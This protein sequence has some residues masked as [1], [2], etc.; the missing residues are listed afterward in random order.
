DVHESWLEMLFTLSYTFLTFYLEFR[1][2]REKMKFLRLIQQHIG[3]ASIVFRNLQKIVPT[4]SESGRFSSLLASCPDWSEKILLTDEDNMKQMVRLSRK[5]KVDLSTWTS[6]L[7]YGKIGPNNKTGI[8]QILLEAF[9]PDDTQDFLLRSFSLPSGRRTKVLNHA[10]PLAWKPGMSPFGIIVECD[11]ENYAILGNAFLEGRLVMD[12]MLTIQEMISVQVTGTPIDLLEAHSIQA[13]AS[14]ENDIY[15]DNTSSMRKDDESMRK[16][17]ESMR[18]DD[19]SM[20][21]DDESMRKDETFTKKDLSV[22]DEFNDAMLDDLSDIPDYDDDDT[23]SEDEIVETIPSIVQSKPR[24]PETASYRGRPN[25]SVPDSPVAKSKPKVTP[26]G[27]F[28]D[29]PMKPPNIL[30][31]CGKKDSA[32]NYEKV[33]NSLEQ[34]VNSDSYVIYNLKHDDVMKVPWEDNAAL[35]VVTS[36]RLY[37]GLDKAFMKFYNN[38]GKI[39]SFNSNL[40]E[41]FLPRSRLSSA[42]FV[43]GIAYKN[44]NLNYICGPFY[45]DIDIK[46]SRYVTY[47]IDMK[48]EKPLMVRVD[49]KTSAGVAM[50]SQICLDKDPY[51]LAVSEET[52][53]LLQQSNDERFN[54][55]GDILEDLGIDCSMPD[56]PALTPAY[57]LSVSEARAMMFLHALTPRFNDDGILKST[58]GVS[59]QFIPHGEYAPEPRDDFLPVI[60]GR[61]I[62]STRFDFETY[63]KYLDADSLGKIIL[64]T[65]VIPTTMDVFDPMMFYVPEEINVAC[66]AGRQ[67][68]GKGRGGN[69]WLSPEGCAMFSLHMNIPLQSPLGQRVSMI[70]HIAALAVT[71]A[72]S[73]VPEYAA[74]NIK[75][76]WPNDIYFA[77]KVKIGGVFVKSTVLS[78]RLHAIIG[79]GV[80]VENSKP[81]LCLNDVVYQQNIKTGANLEMWTR[82][83]LI[84]RTFTWMEHLI[85][86]IQ[87]DQMTKFLDLYYAAWLHSGVVVKVEQ[88]GQEATVV[89]IDEHG[90]LSVMPHGSHKSVSL[91]P[92]GNSFD[93]MKN[94]IILK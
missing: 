60:T 21:K 22:N 53:A 93:I 88:T 71:Q 16:D 35:L 73:E 20:R 42:L 72:I 26:S 79:C 78:D 64:Y 18:K 94:L 39:V 61:P 6:Y 36:E 50:L 56:M 62:D 45:Y 58:R 40:D 28:L 57:L 46:D 54:V 14:D 32:R 31:Y 83:R 41:Q 86:M 59:L 70:Q 48:S 3:D 24:R 89:G 27:G 44:W 38:G 66:I 17:G 12:E 13:S 82:E 49:S 76:K 4:L 55:L 65:D 9:Q 75:V 81:N 2:R 77:D 8:H 7:D 1:E 25:S 63:E 92:D 68:S 23:S 33:K 10:T 5:M 51:D 43:S 85:Q 67:T 30:V 47:A 29:T 91:Q 84:A 52:F 19:E 11:S 87:N 74:C 69:V 34:C 80:N 90:Y 15:E 37:D